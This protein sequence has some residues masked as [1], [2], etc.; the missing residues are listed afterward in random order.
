MSTRYQNDGRVSERSK[1]VGSSSGGIHSKLR[2]PENDVDFAATGVGEFLE[3]DPRPTFV[4]CDE[5][6]DDLEPVYLNRAIRANE[7][8]TRAI[9]FKARPN[10]PPNPSKTSGIEFVSWVREVSKVKRGHASTISFL[11]LIWTGFTVRGRWVVVSGDLPAEETGRVAVLHRS[12][13]SRSATEKKSIDPEHGVSVQDPNDSRNSDAPKEPDL[14]PVRGI[15][16][17]QELKCPTLDLVLGNETITYRVKLYQL[18]RE[19]RPRRDS[20]DDLV[21]VWRL[22]LCG[23]SFINYTIYICK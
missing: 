6:G 11:G 19:I 10:S 4:V 18:A 17:H 15:S 5:F 3:A 21:V 8:L 12:D 23:W 1:H 16:L 22:L 9:P 7:Q 2:T 20:V 13:S 14:I